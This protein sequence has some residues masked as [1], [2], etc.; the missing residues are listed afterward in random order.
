[1]VVVRVGGKS[2]LVSFFCGPSRNVLLESKWT[3][4]GVAVAKHSSVYQTVAVVSFCTGYE[5]DPSVE[6]KLDSFAGMW[7]NDL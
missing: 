3:K 4:V 7:K 1:M 2:H 5:V 6:S